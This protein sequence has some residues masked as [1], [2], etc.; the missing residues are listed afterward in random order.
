MS[1]TA[2]RCYEV[3]GGVLKVSLKTDHPLTSGEYAALDRV[4]SS[5]LD[6]FERIRASAW[7]HTDDDDAIEALGGEENICAG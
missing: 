6:C 2:D 5:Y 7:P 3:S 1:H 4:A